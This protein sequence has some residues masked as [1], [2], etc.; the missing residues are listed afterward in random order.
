MESRHQTEAAVRALYDLFRE[1][2]EEN[3]VLEKLASLSREDVDAFVNSR[4][5]I[6]VPELGGDI[7]VNGLICAGV[8]LPDFEKAWRLLWD[9]TSEETRALALKEKI[10][11]LAKH[12]GIPNGLHLICLS[13]PF[14]SLAHIAK[15]A[16]F[17]IVEC[18]SA[19]ADTELDVYEGYITH[20]KNLT[21]DQEEQIGQEYERLY[22]AVEKT[23][24]EV[25]NNSGRFL[26]FFEDQIEFLRDSAI[27]AEG[28]QND[29]E[30]IK[31]Y[32]EICTQLIATLDKAVRII[33]QKFPDDAVMDNKERF[34]LNSLYNFRDNLYVLKS[35]ALPAIDWEVQQLS[36]LTH[37]MKILPSREKML[38]I[39]NLLKNPV[40][41]ADLSKAQ[42]Q[43]RGLRYLLTV[44]RE[45]AAQAIIKGD[46]GNP[47]TQ[48]E[49]DTLFAKAV[50]SLFSEL[51]ERIKTL[52]TLASNNSRSFFKKKIDPVPLEILT[53]TSKNINNQ[54]DSFSSDDL[55]K[56]LIL[57]QD[58]VP[59]NIKKDSVYSDL[60]KEIELTLE[61]MH[62]IPNRIL[63]AQPLEIKAPEIKQPEDIL[64]KEE[65]KDALDFPKETGE[66][67]GEVAVLKDLFDNFD[68]IL[69]Q[70]QDSPGGKDNSLIQK[71]AGNFSF[72]KKN[73][74]D[75]KNINELKESVQ[76][77]VDKC[78]TEGAADN[79]F[80]EIQEK[81]DALEVLIQNIEEIMHPE[82]QKEN[83]G[84]RPGIR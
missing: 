61:A 60:I 70:I 47:K 8:M 41:F 79:S 35:R 32:L 51:H 40:Y 34:F 23:E 55:K 36:H 15:T 59:A 6:Q 38:L 66:Q 82:G 28:K 13:Q 18:Y 22:H 58:K 19:Y 29:E 56:M 62:S 11:A 53:I 76:E 43:A 4:F 65:Q 33:K 80:S 48:K 2:K 49:Y 44:H 39:E 77:L 46:L 54:P 3:K 30:A 74:L 26:A 52:E 50:G 31:A 5:P 7:E 68:L 42:C 12:E 72:L 9:K 63:S 64:Q 45:D 69:K 24:E 16:P 17:L 20:N 27:F 73:S 57:I 21:E 83:T 78:N 14:A 81:I 67:K 10:N 25:I 75:E 1:E 37:P 84:R 71:I